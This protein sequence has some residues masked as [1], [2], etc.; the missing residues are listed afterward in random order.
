VGIIALTVRESIELG[1][2]D[3]ASETRKLLM[4]VWG[5]GHRQV[6]LAEEYLLKEGVKLGARDWVRVEL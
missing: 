2:E 5:C 1:E 3:R 4:E 6:R